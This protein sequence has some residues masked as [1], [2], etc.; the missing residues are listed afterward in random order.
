MRNTDGCRMCGKPAIYGLCDKCW[1]DFLERRE[2]IFARFYAEI[3]TTTE[4]CGDEVT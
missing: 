4:N 3:E 2:S 1:L